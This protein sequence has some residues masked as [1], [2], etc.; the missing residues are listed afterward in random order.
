VRSP[1]ANPLARE[2]IDGAGRITV[3]GGGKTRVFGISSP[4][5]SKTDVTI[6]GLT[7]SGGMVTVP[8]A[9][10][11]AGSIVLGGGILNNGSQLT[12]SDVTLD[13]NQVSAPNSSPTNPIYAAG[14]GI[15]NVFGATLT[16]T[17]GTFTNNLATGPAAGPGDSMGGGIF[18]DVRS[19][20]TVS[21]STFTANQ[22]TQGNGGVTFGSRGGAIANAGG[23]Q[24]MVSDSSTDCA[25]APAQLRLPP[26]TLR[27]ITPKRNANSARQLVASRP[28]GP[29]T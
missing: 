3:S 20:L 9:G 26:Q 24:A 7:I 10:P 1:W 15:A 22:T 27:R 12:L 23:S 2:T 28:G 5:S 19:T 8:T 13:N 14:G 11:P 17:D 6:R 4:G 25:R 21:H 18:N 16:T 29:G